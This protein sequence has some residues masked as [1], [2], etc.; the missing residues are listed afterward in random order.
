MTISKNTKKLIIIFV[1]CIALFSL[2]FWTMIM[3]LVP[4]DLTQK[5]SQKTEET[6]VYK[7]MLQ[8]KNQNTSLVWWWVNN[9]ELPSNNEKISDLNQYLENVSTTQKN[10]TINDEQKSEN[11]DES[12]LENNEEKTVWKQNYT[13]E[14]KINILKQSEL[15]SKYDLTAEQVY[16]LLYDLDSLD[17]N[18]KEIRT[19]WKKFEDMQKDPEYK[20]KFSVFRAQID[21]SIKL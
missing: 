9:T 3:L 19:I 12:K 10:K 1:A 20:E 11:N 17:S 4:S 2:I 21:D 16:A 15:L 5:T 18:A 6:Q 8:D 7:E 13:K 14:E